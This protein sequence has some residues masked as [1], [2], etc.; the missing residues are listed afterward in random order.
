[1]PSRMVRPLHESGIP[2]G[3]KR[4]IVRPANRGSILPVG[5]FYNGALTAAAVS[6]PEREVKWQQCWADARLFEAA[7]NPQREKY[8]VNFPYPY[9]NGYPHLGHGF[10]LLRAEMMARYQR[11]RGRNVLWPFAFHCT[12]TPIAAAA[13]RVAEQEPSQLRALEQM[14]ITGKLAASL[15]EPQAWFEHFPERFQEDLQALGLAVDWRR[16][17]ITTDQNP[18]YDTFIRWQFNRLR[19]GDYLR[20]G[21]FPVV[22][23]PERETVVGDHDRVSGEGETPQEYCLLKFR[24]DAGTLVAATLRPETVF[25]QTN[26]WVDGSGTYA[27]ARVDGEAW[28]CSLQMPAKLRLQGHEVEEL[29]TIAG[30]EL[31]GQRYAPPGIDREL[32]VLPADFCDA[33]IGSG[34]VTSV[35]SD[36]PD[37]WQGLADLQASAALCAKWGLDYQNIKEIEPL[38]IIDSGELGTVPAPGLCRQMGVRD[39]HDRARL[40][41][42]KQQLYLHS[43]QHGTMLDS[44]GMGC[45]G[46]PVD[47]AREKVREALIASGDAVRYYELT[48]PAR[49]RWLTDCTVKIVED[50]WFLKYGDE[51]WTARTR[52]ALDTMT[53][54]PRKARAQFEHVLGWLRDWACAREQGL[55]TRLPW[56]DKWVI[57]SLSD[58][59]I[60]MAYYTIAHH[61][62]SLPAGKLSEKLFEAL[63]GDGDLGGVPGVDAEQVAEWRS[64]FEYWYPYDLRVSGKDLIQNHLSFSLFNHTAVFPPEK[65]PRGFAVNGWVLVDGEKM[66]KSRGNFY[67]IHQLIDRYGADATRL[68]LCNSGEGLDDPNWEGSFA[69]SA[70]RKLDRWLR[71]VRD[72]AG[73]GRDE[74]HPVDDW[75]A[76]MLSQA[77]HDARRACDRMRFRTAMRGLF[78]ELPRHYRWYLRRCG[79]PRRDLLHD[80]LSTV[81]R[82]LAPVVP[83]LA[84]EAWEILGGDGFVSDAPYPDGEPALEELLRGEELVQRT[85]ADIEAILKVARIASPQAITLLITPGWK[86]QAVA[87]ASGL[88]DERGRVDMQSLM[89]AAMATLPAAAKQEAAAFLKQWALKEIPSLGPSW[90][91]RY[92]ERLDEAAVLEQAAGFLAGAFGCGVT[93]VAAGDASGDAASKA[94]QAAPLRPAIFVK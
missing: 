5:R 59:T 62:N 60:Y 49:S 93:V 66:S 70:G 81:T 63:F 87:L 74:P 57:E 10:T 7:P 47:A 92:A 31:I 6:V 50:Q 8:F 61:V 84:E 44:V 91:A 2:A 78:F 64:E 23:C 53:L 89:K 3:P 34:I 16:S 24:G 14:G 36:A 69:D 22:W 19:E 76:A 68:T 18:A 77:I 71:F 58:S 56:D 27:H 51:A 80:Y 43:F 29:S 48:G 52:E 13:Q 15:A 12:G 73:S 26:L 17:F 32:I 38:A 21:S 41:E 82:G 55:G 4:I 88:A 33:A 37:D 75:F 9:V 72:N 86:W 83:H 40:E 28:V 1:M 65:W 79:K 39:Q 67:T 20:K 25:G 11:M 94:R 54:F 46:L 85:H 45:A 90:A 42:A 30:R 35:P